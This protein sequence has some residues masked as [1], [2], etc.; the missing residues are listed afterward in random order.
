MKAKQVAGAKA[1]KSRSKKTASEKVYGKKDLTCEALKDEVSYAISAILANH[2]KRQQ[3]PEAK[4]LGAVS[5]DVGRSFYLYMTNFNEYA[6]GNPSHNDPERRKW[7]FKN[8]IFSPDSESFNL[9]K[10]NSAT[11]RT[12]K[13]WL[14]RLFDNIRREVVAECSKNNNNRTEPEKRAVR[15]FFY[16]IS[17]CYLQKIPG[18][19]T[20]EQ[21]E[22]KLSKLN[23]EDQKEL[24]KYYLVGRK[25]NYYL[26]SEGKKLKSV[27]QALLFKTKH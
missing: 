15:I 12:R 24:G 13:D 1:R 8:L 14:G 5:K 20:V 18:R 3:L 19:L 7:V 27:I 6:S 22:K 23:E 2:V 4:I 11:L 17:A 26:T 10:A 16:I 21:F 25:G 9:S